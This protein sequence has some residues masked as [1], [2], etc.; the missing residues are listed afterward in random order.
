M[1]KRKNSDTESVY[2]PREN[3]SKEKET[4][5]R[6]FID[7]SIK[8]DGFMGKNGTPSSFGIDPTVDLSP[9]KK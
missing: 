5:D 1:K 3:G 4:V 8:S 7:M 2:I 9:R 6:S